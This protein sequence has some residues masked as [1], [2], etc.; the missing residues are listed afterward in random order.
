MNREVKN[1][2][3]DH[4]A[5]IVGVTVAIA[6]AWMTIDWVSFDI[7]KE[8]PKLILSAIIAAGG[9]VSKVKLKQL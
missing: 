8:W 7:K 9:I 6:S 4:S 2:L 5:T 1:K 3:A